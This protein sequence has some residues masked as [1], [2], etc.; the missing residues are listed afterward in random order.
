MIAP[1]V[2]I[3]LAKIEENTRALVTRLAKRG[4]QVTGVTKATLGSPDIARAMVRGGVSRLADSRV[5]NLEALQE[6]GI[7]MPLMLLRAP[8]PEWA[9]R[10]VACAQMSLV[11]DMDVALALAAAAGRRGSPHGIVLM[12]ELG[13]LREGVMTSNV[14]DAARVLSR[15]RHLTLAGLGTNLAC[16]SGVIPGDEQMLELGALA[17][18]VASKIG[19]KELLVSGGNS[20][21]V[22][23]AFGPGRVGHINDLR[24]GEAI[25][26]GTDPVTRSPIPG[27]HHD[28]FTLVG[29]V[30]ESLEKPSVPWG[31][32][33][34]ASLG[35]KPGVRDRGTI[36]QT[37]V[38]LGEQDTN[39]E[40]LT[41][42]VGV[43][44]I[45][46]SSDHLILETPTRLVAGTELRFG[47]DY[48]GLLRAMTSPFVAER[49]LATIAAAGVGDNSLL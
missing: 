23:W 14:L 36:I 43:T 29:S 24:I 2:E 38:A 48:A 46:S 49:P 3:D 1:R 15:T 11:G 28:A 35:P 30:I 41:P 21:N 22:R 9:D 13:D 25:L 33:G 18:L 26:L 17:N 27:L 19:V 16:R 6:S 20:A 32:R 34:H 8:A 45:G 31:S 37:I 44:V 39:P 12:V 5:E 4:I 40:G 42:P 10:A 47:V 7:K